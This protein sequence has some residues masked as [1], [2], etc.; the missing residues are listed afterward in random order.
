M[1]TDGLERPTY[2]L[3]IPLFN[4]EAVLPVLLHRLDRLLEALDGPA[5][6]ILVDDGSR[7]ATGCPAR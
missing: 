4:E 6:V 5:E 7:D 1:R 3:V 2:S